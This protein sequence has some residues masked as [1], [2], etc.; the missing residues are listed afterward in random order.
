MLATGDVTE[1]AQSSR[2]GNKSIRID[3]AVL[4][5]QLT[6]FVDDATCFGGLC[7]SECDQV[8]DQVDLP[9]LA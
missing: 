3:N 1:T 2:I 5:N 4:H 9:V 8:S 7:V 6:D